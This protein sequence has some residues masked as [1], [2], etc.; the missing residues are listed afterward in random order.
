MFSL[1]RSMGQEGMDMSVHCILVAMVLRRTS[2]SG[3]WGNIS[4]NHFQWKM[5]L[6][7]GV[8]S[9]NYKS[10]YKWLHD[11]GECQCFQFTTYPMTW[12]CVTDNSRLKKKKKK[13]GKGEEIIIHKIFKFKSDGMVLLQRLGTTL[14]LNKFRWQQVIFIFGNIRGYSAGQILRIDLPEK[15][16]L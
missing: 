12:T 10:R 6:N 3:I 13:L 2:K 9:K 8:T 4:V 5:N 16:S 11:L 14:H 7:Q 1:P 15:Q